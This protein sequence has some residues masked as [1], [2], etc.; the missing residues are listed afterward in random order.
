VGI[1]TTAMLL[2]LAREADEASRDEEPKFAEGDN[3]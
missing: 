2:D 3:I 1:A